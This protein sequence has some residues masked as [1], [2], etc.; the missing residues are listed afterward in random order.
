MNDVEDSS[1]NQCAIYID[2]G[3]TNTRV[4]AVRGNQVDAQAN[5]SAGVRD[6]AREGTSTRIRA[7]LRELIGDV[8]HEAERTS[9]SFI[10]ACVAAAGMIG[11]ALGLAEV[12]YVFAPAGL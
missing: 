5:K 3:T 7:A 9:G 4:Y 6:T 10:P 1:E 8:R 2:L 12:P 11:S